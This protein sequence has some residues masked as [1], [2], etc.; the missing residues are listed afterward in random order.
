MKNIIV[1]CIALLLAAGNVHP[2]WAVDPRPLLNNQEFMQKAV[3]DV[4]KRSLKAGAFSTM[5]LGDLYLDFTPE[6]PEQKPLFEFVAWLNYLNTHR[7]LSAVYQDESIDQETKDIVGSYAQQ[8]SQTLYSIG[9]NQF[10]WNEEDTD[11]VY[12]YCLSLI[13]DRIKYLETA[14]TAS[15]SSRQSA[16]KPLPFNPATNA[17][18]NIVEKCAM[19]M[20]MQGQQND[21]AKAL[22]T[23]LEKCLAQNGYSYT[24]TLQALAE[25]GFGLQD[26]PNILFLVTPAGTAKNNKTP[27]S[28][29]YSEEEIRYLNA[30]KER[31]NLDLY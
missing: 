23:V 29:I 28:E 26:L 1:V 25:K 18:N 24:A 12:T 2:C 6:Q 17:T 9:E 8:I 15:E 27:L 22:R 30:I 10:G 3:D 4:L 11:K 31:G 5:I 19:N 14:M 16:G 7:L 13:N 21:S 20:M